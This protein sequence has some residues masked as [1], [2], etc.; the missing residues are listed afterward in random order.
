MCLSFRNS[1][2]GILKSISPRTKQATSV[3]QGRSEENTQ[4][5][6]PWPPY[7]LLSDDYSVSVDRLF[8]NP[9]L[10]CLKLL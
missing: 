5:S 2:F 4:F 10:H 6:H 1:G 3:L 7:C 9:L 8:Y